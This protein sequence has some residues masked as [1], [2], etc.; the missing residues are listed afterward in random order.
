MGKSVSPGHR[1]PGGLEF[2]VRETRGMK[3]TSLLL[4]LAAALSAATLATPISVVPE[5]DCLPCPKLN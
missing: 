2:N 5:P 3:K 4:I 1:H